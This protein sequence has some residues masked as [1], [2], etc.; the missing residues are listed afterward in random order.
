[1]T[2]MQGLYEERIGGT[3]RYKQY[4]WVE[5]QDYLWRKPRLSVEDRD[6]LW[7]KRVIY[8]GPELSVEDWSYL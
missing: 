3:I 4:G 2:E 5:D 1:M 7:R 8:R 6:Y